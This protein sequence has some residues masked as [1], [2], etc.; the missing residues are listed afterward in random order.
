MEP[1]FPKLSKVYKKGDRCI[2]VD[3]NSSSY[4]V[5]GKV[6]YVGRPKG[7]KE[8]MVGVEFE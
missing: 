1:N 8:K 5:K 6:L 2:C 7:H 4:M 3:K